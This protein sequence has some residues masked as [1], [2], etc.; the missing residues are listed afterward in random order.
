MH[1]G[2]LRENLIQLV[3]GE[4]V[5]DDAQ[6]A[7]E[8]GLDAAQGSIRQ[9]HPVGARADEGDVGMLDRA[10]SH[11]VGAVLD[12]YPPFPA[13]RIVEIELITQM[14]AA[15]AVG[16]KGMLHLGEDLVGAGRVRLVAGAGRGLR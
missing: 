1:P 11:G 15:R 2:I 3:R 9:T 13:L 12:L 6:A 7:G 16:A 4:L 8:E 14:L 5:S 10:F